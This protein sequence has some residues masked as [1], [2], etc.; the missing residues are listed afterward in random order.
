VPC[1]IIE[2]SGDEA[3]GRTWVRESDG[4]VLQQEITIDGKNLILEREP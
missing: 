3:S 4:L 1:R 2:Y